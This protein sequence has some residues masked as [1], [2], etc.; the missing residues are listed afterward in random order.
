ML[1]YGEHIFFYRIKKN[2]FLVIV[3]MQKNTFKIGK[4]FLNEYKFNLRLTRLNELKFHLKINFKK[5]PSQDLT[6]SR[7]R[8]SIGEV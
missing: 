4:A 7:S 1:K 8:R 2:N 3:I 5:Y 6:N